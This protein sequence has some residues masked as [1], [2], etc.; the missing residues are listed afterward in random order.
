MVTATTS[1]AGEIIITELTLRS[2]SLTIAFPLLGI[3][4]ELNFFEDIYSASMH[5]TILLPEG[6]NLKEVFPLIGEEIITFSGYTPAYPNSP[7][8]KTFSITGITEFDVA[9]AKKVV[10]LLNFVSAP[11]SINLYSKVCCAYDD[12]ISN[13]VL[14]LFTKSF[15]K[16]VINIEPTAN[17]I[18]LVAPT[19]SPFE[20]LNMFAAKALTSE[21]LSN[22]LFYE[23][24]QIF[25]FKSLSSMFAQPVSAVFKKA[26]D[27]MRIYTPV[28]GTTRDVRGEYMNVKDMKVKTLFHNIERVMSGAYGHK[29]YDVD[30]FTK[31]NKIEIYSYQ[32][33]FN[34]H[35][36]LNKYPVN[37][38]IPFLNPE[39]ANVEAVIGCSNYQNGYL[40]DNDGIIKTKRVPM[41]SEASF[42]KLELTTHGRTD[43]R[44]GNTITFLMGKYQT[45]DIESATGDDHLDKYYSG[46]YLISAIHHR[47]TLTRHETIMEVIKDSFP[48]QLTL[49]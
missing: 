46:K 25:N 11:T 37:T 32:N 48:T 13:S 26:F 18:K 47:I 42:I 7:I 30:I 36:H 29:V 23:D 3:F 38:S 8:K 28:V 39:N 5:G 19:I 17:S 12:V 21:G 40:I 24:N 22:F 33:N 49:R 4:S 20:M 10:Y 44:V 34:D 15:P 9:S 45:S 14:N 2:N 27:R 16:S 35:K 41:L 31:S 6:F 43:I 1:H